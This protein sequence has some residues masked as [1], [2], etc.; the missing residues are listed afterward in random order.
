MNDAWEGGEDGLGNTEVDDGKVG[1]TA[2]W[3]RGGE[4][5]W[6]YEGDVNV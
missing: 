1:Y 3:R 4:V 2:K 5:E 6:G